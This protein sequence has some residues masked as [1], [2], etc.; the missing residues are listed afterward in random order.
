MRYSFIIPVYNGGKYLPACVD[1][2]R[3]VTVQEREI[4]LIDDGSTDG[5]GEVCDALAKRYPDVRVIHQVNGGAAAA[6]SRGIREARGENILFV[7]ADDTIDAEALGAVLAD[8]RCDEADLV[9]YGIRFDYYSGGKCY[10]RDPL[11]FEC[12]GILDRKAWAEQ[13]AQLY[14]RNALSSMCTKIFKRRI[15]LEHQLELNTDMF[16]YEDFEFV[17]RYL[18]HC[19]RI[20]NVPRAIYHYRQAED[21]GNAGRRLARIGC[22]SEFLQPIEA[23][24]DGLDNVDP[25]QRETVLVQLF[26]VL[27]REKI[28]VSTL[29][30]IRGICADY[31]RWYESRRYTAGDSRFHRQLVGRKAAALLLQDKKTAL[32]HKVAVWAKAHHLFKRK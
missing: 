28:A 2:I 25:G 10:R 7:D 5:T 30:Q 27:A 3:A 26:Q 12:D 15:L 6:R 22:L 14:A 17:L 32:R 4:L 19:G 13:F 29:D 1:G 23:A 11:Y 9:I 21:E 31:A 8:P 24:L 18:G 16:L 20:W